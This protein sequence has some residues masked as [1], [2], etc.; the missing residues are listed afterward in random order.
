MTEKTDVDPKPGLLFFIYAREAV[1]FMARS[2]MNDQQI[3]CC[4]CSIRAGA[5][6]EERQRVEALMLHNPPT[7]G[8]RSMA[9]EAEMGYRC[10]ETIS[11]ARKE[12]RE[13]QMKEQEWEGPEA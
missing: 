8:I 5:I 10:R 7:P 6:Y 9:M 12:W 1:H 13:S 2:G 3:A 11:E 4:L